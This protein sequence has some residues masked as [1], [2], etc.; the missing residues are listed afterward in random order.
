MKRTHGGPSKTSDTKSRVEEARVPRSFVFRRGKVGHSLIQ[1][2]E[3][4][5]RVMSPNTA[6]HLKESKKNQLRDFL[7]VAPSLDVSHFMIL[8]QTIVGTNLR[9]IRVPRGPTLTFRILS[10][11]LMKDV[12]T[13]QKKP[14]SP[15]SEFKHPPLV[16]LNNFNVAESKSRRAADQHV[17]LLAVTFQHMF[18][19]IDVK[20]I[21][22]SDCRRVVLLNYDADKRTVEWR[23][24]V[25]NASPVGLSKSVKQIIKGRIPNLHSKADISDYVENPG[26][27]SDSEAEDAT[28]AKVS[29]PQHFV[30]RGNRKAQKSAIR[31]KELGPRLTLQLLKIEEEFCSGRVLYHDYLHKTEEEAEQLKQSKL[32]QEKE[33]EQRKKEQEQN[34]KRKHGEEEQESENEEAETEGEAEFQAFRQSQSSDQ[35]SLDQQLDPELGDRDSALDDTPL[36]R[37]T[38]LR[39]LND[40][41]DQEAKRAKKK[42]KNNVGGGKAKRQRS[43]RLEARAA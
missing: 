35:D 20:N 10:Y 1:L 14:H 23:H 6:T 28:D 31:L 30:G 22:L 16:V 25:V 42:E 8:S 24:Y 32:H 5:R 11:A 26:S 13:Q 18:P 3:D 19:Q 34:V 43:H 7:N 9:V 15:G 41:V 33:K 4:L 17:K 21:A 29:L 40:V 38:E 2:V 36:Q 12:T 27:V 37:Q 39:I